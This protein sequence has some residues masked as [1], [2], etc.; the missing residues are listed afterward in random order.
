M[1]GER[2]VPGVAEVLRFRADLEEAGGGGAALVVPADVA[3]ALGPGKRPPVRATIGGH[4]FPTRLAVYGGRSLL[5]VTKANRAAAGIAVGDTVDVAV[6][7]DE[8][9]R[10]VAVPPD[11]Q[12]ALDVDAAAAATFAGLS[13][14][15]R[16][17]Y[18]Q[19]I[20]EAKRPETRARRVAGTLDRLHAHAAGKGAR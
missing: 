5:G 17:E 15:H 4:T 3:A 19:W 7:R 16:R 2:R 20:A 12:A 13:F 10:E 6:A 18:V 14:S 9:P 11:L 1:A 8:A